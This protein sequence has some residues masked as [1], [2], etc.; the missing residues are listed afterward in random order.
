MD[1]ERK[2]FQSQCTHTN[3]LAGILQIY[4]QT[5]IHVQTH[6]HTHTHKHT[7][8]H[9]SSQSIFPSCLFSIFSSLSTISLHN[10][11]PSL[12]LSTILLYNLSPSLA[13][14]HSLALS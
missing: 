3:N 13:L 4:T 5:H 1:G 11:S 7:H 6:R 12:S 9:I 14:S 8:T 2:T 10:L